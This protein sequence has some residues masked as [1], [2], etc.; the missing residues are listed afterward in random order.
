M[1]LTHVGVA[2]A[3]LVGQIVVAILAIAT[4]VG[5]AAVKTA[6]AHR[7]AAVAQVAAARCKTYNLGHGPAD[8]RTLWE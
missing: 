7:A 5:A 2:R 8:S 4:V 6:L 1:C 3:A